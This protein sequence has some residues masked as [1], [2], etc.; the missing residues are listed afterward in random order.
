V[1]GSFFTVLVLVGVWC[2]WESCFV[3]DRLVG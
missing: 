2:Q 3:V 1:R